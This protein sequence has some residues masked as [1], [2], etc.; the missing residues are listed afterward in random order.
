[1]SDT[2]A[3]SQFILKALAKENIVLKSKG[4][5]VFS[6]TYVADAV[7]AILF[8]MLN[9]EN[10]QAYNIA[11]DS[12][13]VRLATFAQ[14]CADL[15]GKEVVFDL[16]SEVESRGYSVASKA[17][18]STKKLAAIGWSSYRTFEDALNRTVSI[19]K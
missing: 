11:C 15:S 8:V 4:N 9:G 1:M 3:S 14:T 5:Q 17:V 10:G 18:M 12:C 7:Q 19:L 16:P 2:K 13:N 6:Y